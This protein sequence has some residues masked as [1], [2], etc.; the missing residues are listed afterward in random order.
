V[1]VRS[2]WHGHVSSAHPFRVVDD[3]EDAL[4]LYIPPGA[5]FKRPLLPGGEHARIPHRNWLPAHQDEVWRGGGVLRLA[6]S[7]AE[8]SVWGFLDD[9]HEAVLAWY[10]NLEAASVRTR[11]GFDTRDHML[12][13]WVRPDLSSWRWK[14]EDELAEAVAAGVVTPEEAAAF[15]AEGERAVALMEAGAH[16]VNRDWRQWLP[17]P[18]WAV[19]V[20]PPGWD[21]V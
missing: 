5:V 10:V 20:L 13:M 11:L 4:A 19:P 9:G 7:G 14:D 18:A 21:V 12:D 8:H 1:V 15:R 16:L 3:S 2:V 17:D 6:M